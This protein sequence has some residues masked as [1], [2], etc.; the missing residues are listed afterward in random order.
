MVGSLALVV[1]PCIQALI[2]CV[3]HV[4]AISLSLAVLVHFDHLFFCIEIFPLYFSLIGKARWA[5]WPL[6]WGATFRHRSAVSNLFKV[7]QPRSYA[8]LVVHGSLCHR[9]LHSGTN[10]LCIVCVCGSDSQQLCRHNSVY[11][12]GT[13]KGGFSTKHFV[14]TPKLLVHL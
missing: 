5:R 9:V 2:C 4:F 3:S 12:W 11:W 8:L 13:E 6:S 14:F 1:G 10:L 7:F